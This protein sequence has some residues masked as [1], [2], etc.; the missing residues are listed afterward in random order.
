MSEFWERVLV[1]AV[2][3][4]LAALV[5]KLVDARIARRT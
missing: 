4:G 1:A 5:A 2:V 3:I